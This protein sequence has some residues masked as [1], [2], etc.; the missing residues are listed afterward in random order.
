MNNFYNTENISSKGRYEDTAVRT[1]KGEPSHVNVFEA[2]LIDN[3]GTKGENVVQNIG[4]GTINPN[5]GMRE[6]SLFSSWLEYYV[7]LF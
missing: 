2:Y 5:T 7:K 1:V 3:Y 6:Y 4:S